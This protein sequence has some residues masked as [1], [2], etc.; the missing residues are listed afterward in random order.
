MR[1]TKVEQ[2][3]EQGA[4]AR[5]KEERREGKNP[6]KLKERKRGCGYLEEAAEE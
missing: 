4:Q 5:S 1:G 6:P 2:R 3:H